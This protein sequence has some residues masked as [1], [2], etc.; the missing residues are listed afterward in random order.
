M[1]KTSKVQALSSPVKEN[2][3]GGIKDDFS[4]PEPG[5]LLPIKVDHPGQ[6]GLMAS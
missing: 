1:Q 6:E 4:L 5:E 2:Q 3:V